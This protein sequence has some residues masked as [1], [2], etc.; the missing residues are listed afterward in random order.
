MSRERLAK[1]VGGDGLEPGRYV[2][3]EVEDEGSG[4]S[5]E[6][7][8][9]AFDPFF[10][11][12]F[13]GRGL[14]LAATLGVV[15]GHSGAI[16]VRSRPGAGTLFRV[17]L[18]ASSE[19]IEKAGA[20]V[21]VDGKGSETILLVD[22]DHGVLDS[23]KRMLERWGYRVYTA[24]GGRQALEE[25]GEDSGELDLALVDVVMPD[26]TA[27]ETITALRRSRPGLPI[28]LW[29]GCCDPES[30][31]DLLEHPTSGFLRKPFTSAQLAALVRGAL[32]RSEAGIRAAAGDAG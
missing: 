3:L 31:A 24:T 8:D 18:P 9:S 30:A 19:G 20:A 29:S 32:S 4:M 17:L 5:Q 28:I 10:T 21:T 13:T 22:D 7:I 23:T 16:E 25:L 15:R 27:S 11:T 12:K 6:V 14:G 2:F 1:A 26:M